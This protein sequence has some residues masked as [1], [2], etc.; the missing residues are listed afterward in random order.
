[1]D[2]LLDLQFERIGQHRGR[3]FHD[4]ECDIQLGWKISD[5]QRVA[6]QM[7][8]SQRVEL[9]FRKSQSPRRRAEG[10]NSHPKTLNPEQCRGV[11]S[12]PGN[13]GGPDQTD[14]QTQQADGGTLG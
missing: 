3:V 7:R 9:R 6:A 13:R 4:P 2:D 1:M 5:R 8:N 11:G 12:G 10:R 14:E